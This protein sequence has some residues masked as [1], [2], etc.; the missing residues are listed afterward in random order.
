MRY[1]FLANLA[2]TDVLSGLVAHPVIVARR[3]FPPDLPLIVCHTVSMIITTVLGA[4]VLSLVALTA[5]QYLAIRHPNVF[6]AKVT[7]MHIHMSIAFTWVFSLTFG[8]LPMM[9]LHPPEQSCNSYNNSPLYLFLTS[10]IFF[11]IPLGFTMCM[12]VSVYFVLQRHARQIAIQ[13]AVVQATSPVDINRERRTWVGILILSIAF[14][15]THAPFFIVAL[16]AGFYPPAVNYTR[17]ASTIT[18]IGNIINPCI[19]A[20][21]SKHFRG[22]CA[23]F[24]GQHFGKCI[25]NTVAPLPQN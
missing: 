3:Y 19:Y 16:T 11:L 10:V 22:V 23:K 9:G 2:V 20:F 24:W 1:R 12:N 5:D 14:A 18:I 21:R 25:G 7:S 15:I 8:L 6:R 4:S 17:L 13:M